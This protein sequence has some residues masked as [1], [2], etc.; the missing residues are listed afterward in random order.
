MDSPW[1]ALDG[2]TSV[3]CLHALDRMLPRFVPVSKVAG[4]SP[5]FLLRLSRA[6]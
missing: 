4:L 1:A 5:V 3:S 6:E 2:S